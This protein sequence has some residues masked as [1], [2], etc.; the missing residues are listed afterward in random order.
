MAAVRHAPLA[1]ECRVGEGPPVTSST[2]EPVAAGAPANA[3]APGQSPVPDPAGE[4]LHVHAGIRGSVIGDRVYTV[5]VTFFALCVPALLILIAIEIFVAGWPALHK[6]G[7]SFLTSSVW[8]PVNGVFG[9]APAIFGTLV[10][11]AMALIIATPLAIGVAV[12]LSEFARP[13]LRQPVAFFVDLLAAIPSV[14]YGLWGIFVLLPM[15]RIRR[16]AIPARHA[17]PGRDPASSRARPTGQACLPR[18]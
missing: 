10:S 6:F 13:E 7:F 11:S 9:A 16:D 15:L 2:V 3:P 8:D 1:D 14:V 4:P 5:L 12:F 17:A 18:G